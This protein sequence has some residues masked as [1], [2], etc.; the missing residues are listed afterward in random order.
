MA[1]VYDII[2]GIN[3]AAAN[4]YDG[5]HEESLSA[6]GKARTVGLSREDGHYI[7]DRRVMDGFKVTIAG[8]LLRIN[9]QAEVLIK[10]VKDARFENDI[11]TKLKDI[12]KFLKKE[13]KKITGN[14]VTLTAEGEIDIRVEN[15]S[16]VR[17]WVVAKKHYKIGGLSEEMNLEAGSEVPAERS[18][19]KFL[20]QGGWGK[21]PKNDTRKKDA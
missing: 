16:R 14:S 11:I 1:T 18:W 9:Y 4:A 5:A 2:K 7:N 17:S 10:D 3:Q 6:D 19:E 21:R 15:S 12:V 8:P 13:Y 20:N